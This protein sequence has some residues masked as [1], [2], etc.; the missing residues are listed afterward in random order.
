MFSAVS[1]CSLVLQG[2]LQPHTVE[3]IMYPLYLSS[4]AQANYWPLR[5]SNSVR[6]LVG[7]AKVPPHL[8][9]RIAGVNAR[10]R[11]MVGATF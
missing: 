9:M 2:S 5:I 7:Q 10:L 8:G 1:T 4:A 11:R 3:H 6:L